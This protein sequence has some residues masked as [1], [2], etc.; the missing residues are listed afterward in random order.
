MD[1]SKLTYNKKQEA[2][3]DLKESPKVILMQESPSKSP[4]V[5]ESSISLQ[6]QKSDSIRDSRF[7]FVMSGGE[8]TERNF[9]KVLIEQSTNLTKHT[10]N[11]QGL[12][13]EMLRTLRVLFLSEDCQGLQ[14]YQM[15]DK[16]DKIKED[17]KIKIEDMEYHLDKM[18]KVFL[19]SDVDEFYDQL[20]KYTRIQDA[21]MQWII[22]NPCFEVWLYYCYFNN[23]MIDLACLEPLPCSERSQKMKSLGN[24]LGRGG[25]WNAV[26]AFEKMHD[27]IE[28]SKEHYAIDENGIPVLYATQM[29]EM[30]QYIINT[31]NRNANVYSNYLIQQ[32]ENRTKWKQR[33]D[34]T[35]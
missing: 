10:N 8:Q 15:N 26:K 4:L 25:G 11:Q 17:G 6:Y 31:L 27:G 34:K 14:P 21:Q 33:I 1:L 3:L 7:I 32:T 18:D 13:E 2:T 23:P 24:T 29:H 28:H 35:K 5:D 12:R 19:L 16:W 22:S 9:F 20:V 30:A